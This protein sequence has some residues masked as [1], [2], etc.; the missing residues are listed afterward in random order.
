MTTTIPVIDYPEC[1][2][3]GVCVQACPFSCFELTKTGL[4]PLNKVYPVLTAIERCTGCAI[5]QKACPVEVIIMQERIP[6]RA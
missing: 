6:E 2:A 4:D 1:I 5:C 3:C